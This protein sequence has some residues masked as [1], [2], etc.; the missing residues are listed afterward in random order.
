[1]SLRFTSP[2]VQR[3]MKNT[4]KWDTVA[5]WVTNAL[6][7]AVLIYYIYQRE[8]GQVSLD[9]DDAIFREKRLQRRQQQREEAEIKRNTE[10]HR[11]IQ[12]RE[13]KERQRE[14]MQATRKLDE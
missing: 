4:S 3:M 2:F 11:L 7:G 1:M 8:T 6:G 10:A 9:D 14:M 5:L 13:E 12:M